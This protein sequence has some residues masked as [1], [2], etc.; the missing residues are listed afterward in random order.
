MLVSNLQSIHKWHEDVDRA[1]D[2]RGFLHSYRKNSE[3]DQE[4]PQSQTV[5]KPVAVRGRAIFVVI[6]T[7]LQML[8]NN[9]QSV[10]LS[11]SMIQ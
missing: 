8:A 6:R 4:I 5:D 9:V 2:M 10:K 1:C 11:V 3:Y 7:L